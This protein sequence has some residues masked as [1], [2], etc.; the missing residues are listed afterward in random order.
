MMSDYL[1]RYT[2]WKG[3]EKMSDSDVAKLKTAIDKS[4][5]LK[6]PVRFWDAPD[7]SDAW[8]VLMGFGVDFINTDKIKELSGF[9]KP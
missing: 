3:T 8:K 1:K 6:K 5:Q 7:N 4:H 2:L 9:L